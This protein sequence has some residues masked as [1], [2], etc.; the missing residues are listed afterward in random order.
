MWPLGTLWGVSDLVMSVPR[1]SKT[2]IKCIFK[3][4]NGAVYVTLKNRNLIALIFYQFDSGN[5]GR[6]GGGGGRY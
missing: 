2:L 5:L 4:S 6:G 1:M 3:Y